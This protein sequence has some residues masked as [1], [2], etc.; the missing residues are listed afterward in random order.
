MRL[1]A[2][3]PDSVTFCLSS[4]AMQYG[5]SVSN[6]ARDQTYQ[7]YQK[8]VNGLRDN[9]PS[10]MRSAVVAERI[11]GLANQRFGTEG[12]LLCGGCW[13]PNRLCVCGAGK[14]LSREALEAFPHRII[15]YMHVKASRR[16]K[17]S[18]P[19]PPPLPCRPHRFALWRELADRVTHNVHAS[20]SKNFHGFAH[21]ILS[22]VDSA[23]RTTGRR[24]Y[25]RLASKDPFF[26]YLYHCRFW[27]YCRSESLVSAGV[28]R[29]LMIAGDRQ[30]IEHGCA[31]AA[32]AR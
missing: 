15:V 3:Y 26:V 11:Y 6:H 9:V 7:S 4:S 10:D 32:G 31:G 17:T 14:A 8:L 30:V 16:A 20:M 5:D 22:N 18:H 2:A 24:M 23:R 28:K 27:F 1:P 21:N 13:L 19:D 29:G 25:S 12:K